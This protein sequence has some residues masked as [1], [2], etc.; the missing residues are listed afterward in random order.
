MTGALVIRLDSG[1]GFIWPVL[2]FEGIEACLF[3]HAEIVPNPAKRRH[4]F[5]SAIKEHI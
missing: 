3:V 2:F 4:T 5:F 1:I